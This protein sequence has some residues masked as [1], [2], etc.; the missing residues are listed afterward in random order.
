MVP[1]VPELQSAAGAAP[2]SRTRVFLSTEW[3]DLLMLNYEIDP[4]LLQPFVPRGTELDSFEGK[5]YVSLVGLRFARTKLFGLISVPFHSNFDEV[6]LRIYVRRRE[7]SETRRGVMFIR[8]IVSLPAVTF[9]ARLAY[10]EN[11][12]TLPLRHSIDLTNSGG[13]I[14]YSWDLQRER[15]RLHG[16]TDGSPSVA[17]DGSLEQFIS[18]HYWGYSRHRDGS[19]LE[20]HVAHEP[21][22]IW[23]AP[24]A[25]FEGE[26]T[27][28]YGSTFGSVLSR[29]PRSAFIADGSLVLVYSARR[30]E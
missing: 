16:Q 1:P 11:Y 12:R 3:R 13:S 26:G 27:A 17:V 23:C 29:P 21:W 4:A 28:L 8:E 24:F 22:R 25:A 14:E 10:A 19:S 9:L 30:I 7:G 6:N 15:F 18:E 5:A 20:Y 2:R